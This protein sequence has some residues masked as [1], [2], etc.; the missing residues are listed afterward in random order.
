MEEVADSKSFIETEKNAPP[1]YFS[2]EELHRKCRDIFPNP[3]EGAKVLVNKGLSQ[4]FQVHFSKLFDFFAY[5]KIE[6]LDFAHFDTFKLFEWLSFWFN[7]CWKL[8]IQ[9]ERSISYFIGGN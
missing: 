7:F 3:F 2:Y 5:N 8:K 1:M 9:S 4:Q 6:F